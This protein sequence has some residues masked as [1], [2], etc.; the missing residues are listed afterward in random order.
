LLLSAL[1]YRIDWGCPSPGTIGFN[2]IFMSA[3]HPSYASQQQVL[4]R[5]IQR[6]SRLDFVLEGK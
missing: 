3:S 4:G 1:W 5:G 2:T 6:V